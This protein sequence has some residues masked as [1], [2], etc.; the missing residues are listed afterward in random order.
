MSGYAILHLDKSPGNESAMTDHIERNVIHPNVDASR[1]HLNK[2]LIEFPEGVKD[3]TEA[4]EHRV[5]NAGLSR[6]VGKNQVKVIRVILSGTHENMIRI[7]QEGKLDDWCKDNIDWLKKEY[8]EEN[9][10]AATLHLDERTPHIHASVV[11]IVRGERRKKNTN[12]KQEEQVPKRQYK[13][14][15]PNRPRLCCDDVM[16]RDKLT[17]Y[18]DSYGDAMAKYGLERGVKGSEARHI[19]TS[20]FYRSQ[21]VNIELLLVEEETKRKN[22]EQLTEKEQE[23]NSRYKQAEVQKQQKE[24]ELEE[25]E[26]ELRQ[27]KNDVVKIGFER[28]AKEVSSAIMDGVGSLFGASKTKKL[29]QKIDNLHANNDN[30]AQENKNL[31]QEMQTKEQEHQSTTSKLKQELDKI[32]SLF[33]KLKELL[34]LERL[35]EHLGFSDVLTQSI[36]RMKPVSFRGKLYSSEYQRKFETEHSVAEVKN[37]PTEKNKL[38]FTIDDVSEV[39]WF[40][41]RQREFL[42]RMGLNIKENEKGRGLKR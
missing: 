12:K 6:Q 25:K 29:E 19:T 24:A 14:K 26:K 16:A 2:E 28:S 37:H 9:V 36:L 23:A 7:Q 4:I 35:C 18:Q 17:Q 1:T 10:V 33:P 41:M 15:N 13:K 21:Q 20:E 5:K 3:R 31:K 11:P 38:Q 32:H 22:I 34:R 40:R 42:E 30:L 8:G 39:S 27:V